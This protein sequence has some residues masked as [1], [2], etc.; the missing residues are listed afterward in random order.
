[1]ERFLKAISD[2]LKGLDLEALRPYTAHLGALGVALL[3]GLGVAAFKVSSEPPAVDTA[4]RWPFPQWAPYRTGPQRAALARAELWA[5]DP[6]KAKAVAEKKV[7]GPPWRFIGT[8]REG[9]TLVAVIE[10]D[11][12]KRIQRVSSGQPL[13]NGAVIKKIDTNTLIY[14]ENGAEKALKLFGIAKT[15]NLAAG[16]GKN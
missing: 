10:L 5:E 8:M 12:G 1:M 11:Q 6:T 2:R 13:P 15:D 16:T 3:L 14:D 4:D 7:E 9:A